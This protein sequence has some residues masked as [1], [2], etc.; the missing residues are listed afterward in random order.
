MTFTQWYLQVDAGLVASHVRRLKFLHEDEDDAHE[1]PEVH[2]RSKGKADESDPG[3]RLPYPCL[4]IPYY[5]PKRVPHPNPA[6]IPARLRIQN[7][8]HMVDMTGERHRRI[9]Q[10]YREM[11]KISLVRQE[12]E[13]FPA[14]RERTDRIGV[15][16][17]F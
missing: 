2:L 4:R 3:Q 11:G 5:L 7:G 14:E 17:S 10:E 16:E 13:Q 9:P 1:E 15:M 12:S 6:E 8:V